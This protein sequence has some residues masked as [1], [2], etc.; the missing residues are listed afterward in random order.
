MGERKHVDYRIEGGRGRVNE[1]GSL[2]GDG[3]GEGW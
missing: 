1:M 3:A 2:I